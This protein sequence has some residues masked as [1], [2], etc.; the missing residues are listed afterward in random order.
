MA[1]EPQPMPLTVTLTPMRRRNVRTVMRIEQ[2]VYPKPWSPALF[3]SE[4]ALRSTRAYV[5]AHV[6]RELVGYG[7][8]MMTLDE[9]HVT[10]I[11]VAPRW[12]RHKIGTRLLLALVRAAVARDAASITLEVRISN[13]AAQDLY[14]RF[15]F[16]PVGVRKG[17]YQEVNEDALVMWAHDVQSSDYAELL[18]SLERGIPGETLGEDARPR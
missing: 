6:G 1:V 5:V 13:S 11:A 9:G 17:Y 12:H 7:G 4:L 16:A 2:E 3:Y 14:R 15:G 10:T 8:L 18:D